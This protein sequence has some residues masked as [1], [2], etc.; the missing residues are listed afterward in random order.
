MSA[1]GDLTR[2]T[3]LQT[4]EV[5]SLPAAIL[6]R[7]RGRV[8][9]HPSIVHDR[10]LTLKEPMSTKPRK[11]RSEVEEMIFEE[12]KP[13]HPALEMVRLHHEAETGWRCEFVWK[14]DGN[15]LVDDIDILRSEA[16]AELARLQPIGCHAGNG[17]AHRAFLVHRHYRHERCAP[18]AAR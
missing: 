15:V 17:R 2:E 14:I 12:L 18:S 8:A 6:R 16:D 5:P 9:R 4:A 3:L 11:K 1:A 7:G 13:R 10:R